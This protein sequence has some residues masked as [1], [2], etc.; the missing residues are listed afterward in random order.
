MS[1]VSSGI[2]AAP[3]PHTGLFKGFVT[4]V[5]VAYL[6]LCAT[7][8][9]FL[10]PLLIWAALG[11]FALALGALA[12]WRW[13]IAA[14]AG[15]LIAIPFLP[16]PTMI[17]Q[18]TGVP[19]VQAASAMK[20]VVL[21]ASAVI[22]AI[23]SRQPAKGGTLNWIL[24]GLLSIAFLHG[25]LGGGWM[26]VKDDFE[27]VIPFLLGRLLPLD[28]AHQ[29]R[30]VRCGLVVIAVVASLGLLEFIF[31]PLEMRMAML[32]I[33]ASEVPS[34]YTAAGYSGT[35]IAS[36][37]A[38][39]AEFGNLCAMAL[40]LF[41]SYRS[42]LSPK[43]YFAVSVV[44]LGLV[45]SVTRSAGLAALVGIG[46]VAIRERKKRPLVYGAAAALILLLVAVPRL[47]LIDYVA[48]A[49]SGDE[50][51]F[52][53]HVESISSNIETVLKHPM[54]TG[55]G[56]VGP[57]AIERSSQ[58]IGIEN[59]FL[60]VAVQYGWLAGLLFVSFFA[61]LALK[62]WKSKSVLG[63]CAVALLACYGLFMAVMPAH[64]SLV[65]ACWVLIPAGVATGHGRGSLP[66]RS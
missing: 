12:I 4:A 57:R 3:S 44:G 28:E 15:V 5:T 10:P 62:C 35:R 40:V 14:A 36:T 21:M 34:Q 50:I 33:A 7:L 60:T 51:S 66:A 47:G 22:L 19:F 61:A 41:Y 1:R 8:A 63:T 52:Q 46:V 64:Q 31:V 53:G 2:C 20:E 32:S 65:T 58:A 25:L 49:T 54:G 56:T 38:G 23:R 37:L 42:R 29:L 43:W 16:L 45:L 26:G 55:A 48:T 30:W 39:P 6:F 17:G 27:L 9:L 18:A 24:F 13:P 11:L 59:S